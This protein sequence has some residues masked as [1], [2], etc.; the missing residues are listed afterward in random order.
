[1]IHFRMLASIVYPASLLLMVNCEKAFDSVAS[2]F[3]E[4]SL[5]VLNFGHYIKRW[6]ATVTINTKSCM[7]VNGQCSEWFNVKRGPR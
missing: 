7:A 2:S 5:V 4:Q 1:M 3:T 6:I